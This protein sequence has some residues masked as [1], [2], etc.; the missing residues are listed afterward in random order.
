MLTL[1]KPM[2]IDWREYIEQRPDVM[3]DM[4]VIK[5]TRI[6]VELILEELGGSAGSYPIAPQSTPC[7]T[8]LSWTAVA[9]SASDG[10]TALALIAPRSNQHRRH[11]SKS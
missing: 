1:T 6:T 8:D 7:K 11:I 5:G 9:E 2:T 10:A 3:P 4:P